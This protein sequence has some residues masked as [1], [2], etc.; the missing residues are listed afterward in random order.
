MTL[1]EPMST[2]SE[3]EGLESKDGGRPFHDRDSDS[4]GDDDSSFRVR[5][6]TS[7]SLP[8]R[9]NPFLAGQREKHW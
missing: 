9:A 7:I 6:R 8:D 4:D 2:D 1:T 5:V 3:H